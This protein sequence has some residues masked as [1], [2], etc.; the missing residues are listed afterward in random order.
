VKVHVSLIQYLQRNCPAVLLAAAPGAV[1]C[2]TLMSMRNKTSIAET[3][4][5][6]VDVRKLFQRF[7]FVSCDNIHCAGKICLSLDFKGFVSK[8]DQNS[9]FDFFQFGKLINQWGTEQFEVQA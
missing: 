4:N 2:D 8:F 7:F 1:L 6:A 5:H 3:Q 9:A